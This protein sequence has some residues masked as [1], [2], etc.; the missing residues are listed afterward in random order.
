[1]ERLQKVIANSGYT[2]RRKAEE[3]IKNGYVYV[4]GNTI[5]MGIKVL[6]RTFAANVYL[7]KCE[8]KKSDSIKPWFPLTGVGTP[9]W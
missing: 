8:N 3:L 1:M 5:Q 6:P 2:S 7:I 9:H 4:N